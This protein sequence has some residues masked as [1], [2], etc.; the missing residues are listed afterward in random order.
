MDYKTTFKK[1]QLRVYRINNNDFKCVASC[2]LKD[3]DPKDTKIVT[4]LQKK[5]KDIKI[6]EEG[7]T[8]KAVS[9]AKCHEN[10][11]FNEQKGKSLAESRC[12]HKIFDRAERIMRYVVKI[13]E[14]E[15]LKAQRSLT[16]YGVMVETEFDH[17]MH[18]DGKKIYRVDSIYREDAE[19]TEMTNLKLIDLEFNPKV[20]GMTDTSCN[21]NVKDEVVARARVAEGDI[22]YI[23]PTNPK[24]IF[25]AS[26]IGLLKRQQLNE[27]KNKNN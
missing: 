27:I 24:A 7:V 1:K 15:Y 5:F 8:F 25:K 2:V 11:S 13:N 18:L 9:Y 22:I 21:L 12:K 23:D 17:L 19:T 20:K 14:A 10:D 3:I 6:T 4:K 16:K 26:Q